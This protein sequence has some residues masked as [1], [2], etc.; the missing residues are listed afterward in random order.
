MGLYE[1][2]DCRRKDVVVSSPGRL[3]AL[4]RRGY[5]DLSQTTLFILDEV[6]SLLTQSMYLAVTDVYEALPRKKQVLAFSATY[7][8]ETLASVAPMTKRVQHI[9]LCSD[10]VCLRGVRQLFSVVKLPAGCSTGDA[11][12]RKAIQL[13]HTL[14]SLAFS[15]ACSSALCTAPFSVHLMYGMFSSVYGH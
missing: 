4:I 13:Q 15:Q 11:M 14:D 12:L 3:S 1:P 10:D 9:R 2:V 5:L 8:E 6:D 7:D